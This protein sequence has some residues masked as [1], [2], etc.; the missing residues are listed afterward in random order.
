MQSE[1]FLD[2]KCTKYVEIFSDNTA[3]LTL[4]YGSS[5][6][7]SIRRSGVKLGDNSTK[8][9]NNSFKEIAAYKKN[10][11]PVHGCTHYM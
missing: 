11:T 4:Y 3:R 9:I 10:V 6:Q 7:Y 2:D 5:R 8:S 1:Y